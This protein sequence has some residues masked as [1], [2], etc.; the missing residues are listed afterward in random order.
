[1]PKI[2]PTDTLAEYERRTSGLLKVSDKKILEGAARIL[3]SYVGHYQ[4]RHGMISAADL[5]TIH[6]ARPG[7]V[8]LEA[9][10]EALR[11]LGAA[12]ALARA[13]KK[14]GKTMS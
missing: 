4:L 14:P 10:V 6:S 7:K 5:A 1:M 9:R 12:L 11:V 3:A 8:Q 2:K 13:V